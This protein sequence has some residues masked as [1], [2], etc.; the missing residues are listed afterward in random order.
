MEKEIRNEASQARTTGT[1]G[2]QIPSFMAEEPRT[3]KHTAPPRLTAKVN[4]AFRK[5]KAIAAPVRAATAMIRFWSGLCISDS[6]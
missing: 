5:N 3:S 4:A 1:A 6:G 2:S